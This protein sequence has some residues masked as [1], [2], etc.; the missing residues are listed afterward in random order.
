MLIAAA[1]QG[2]VCLVWSKT[3]TVWDRRE[4]AVCLAGAVRPRVCRR[5]LPP[6]RAWNVVV[7]LATV[8]FSRYRFRQ[9]CGGL[10]LAITHLPR[11]AAAVEARQ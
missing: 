10:L 9:V 4:G 6:S 7:Y 11:T 3:E 2:G 5:I 8:Q 1:L